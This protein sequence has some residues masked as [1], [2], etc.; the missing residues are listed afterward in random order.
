MKE[1][2]LGLSFLHIRG[3]I[4][5]ISDSK[6][7]G[8]EG[9]EVL[10]ERDLMI[11]NKNEIVIVKLRGDY[12]NLSREGEIIKIGNSI[13]AEVEINNR[14]MIVNDVFISRK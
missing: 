14:D 1:Y 5:F 2:I 10:Y 8:F 11:Q 3:L 13:D 4:L 9:K 6:K 12:V 7:I